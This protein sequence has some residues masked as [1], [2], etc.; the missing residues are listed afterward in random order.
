M[1]YTAGIQIKYN[2]KVLQSMLPSRF[3]QEMIRSELEEVVGEDHIATGEAE[4]LVY[5]VD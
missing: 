3:Q 4:K 1:Q 5:S 2:L